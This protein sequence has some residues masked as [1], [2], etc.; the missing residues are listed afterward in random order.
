M[1]GQTIAQGKVSPR[2]DLK[3]AVLFEE[4]LGTKALIGGNEK[5]TKIN[6]LQTG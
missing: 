6:I 3:E 4:K 2:K 1:Y 5:K